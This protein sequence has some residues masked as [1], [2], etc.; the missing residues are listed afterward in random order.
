MSKRILTTRKIYIIP[1]SERREIE[2]ALNRLNAFPGV[3][4]VL[5]RRQNSHFEIEYDLLKTSYSDI[6]RI[7][8]EQDIYLA[9]G[10]KLT[11]LMSDSLHRATGCFSCSLRRFSE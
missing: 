10:I 5:H 6:E 8:S 4:K 7:L 3:N 9:T 11:D 1:D 2:V